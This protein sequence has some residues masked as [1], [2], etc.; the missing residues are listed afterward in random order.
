MC[1]ILFAYDAHPRYKL[2]LAANRDEFYARPT[3]TA[4]FW[5]DAPDVL[6]GRDRVA[7]GTWLGVTRDGRFAAVTNYRK[8]GAP[9]GSRSRG[10]LVSDFL[11]GELSAR[12]YLQSIETNADEFSGFNLL[13][14]QF[15][16]EEME[17]SYFSNRAARIVDLSPG[18]YGLSNHLLDTPWHKV[19]AGKR[20]LTGIVSQNEEIEAEMLYEILKN[21]AQAADEDLPET[22][23]GLELERIL[24]PAFIKTEIYGT[25][26]S[27]VLLA[28]SDGRIFFE[29]R[30]FPSAANFSAEFTV[31][32]K[33]RKTDPG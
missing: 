24:S 19:V 8:P 11:R 17:L 13:V 20:E 32:K 5:T 25:R 3:A 26:S 23:V 15:G 18:I 22:G 7:G 12:D 9:R 1:L 2:I 14:G 16:V 31:N 6:A 30:N 21:D 28:G 33:A 10:H 29:E 27:T 4:A